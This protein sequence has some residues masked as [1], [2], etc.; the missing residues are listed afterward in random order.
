M[1]HPNNAIKNMAEAI[2]RALDEAPTED[3]LS[4]ITSVF[5]GLTVFAV[6]QNGQDGNKEIKIDGGSRRD[7]TIHAKRMQA[8]QSQNA[9]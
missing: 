7:I 4:L 3:V 8:N 1:E 2:E 9:N 5:V 6:T